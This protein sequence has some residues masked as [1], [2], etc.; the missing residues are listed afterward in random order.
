M[1]V[2]A[3]LSG[4][5]FAVSWREFCSSALLTNIDVGWLQNP[6]Y[7]ADAQNQALIRHL[8]AY[9]PSQVSMVSA[10]TDYSILFHVLGGVTYG[11]VLLVL[12]L[13]IYTLRMRLVNR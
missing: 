9:F 5:C 12:A 6:I 7:Y 1:V 8:P 11:V 4:Q 3:C 10:F 2:T 13:L